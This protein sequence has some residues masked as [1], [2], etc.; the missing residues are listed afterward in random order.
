MPTRPANPRRC[1]NSHTG[2]HLWTAPANRQTDADKAV[3]PPLWGWYCAACGAVKT[4]RRR[5]TGDE[6]R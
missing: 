1:P 4:S 6:T 2:M 5:D 3:R